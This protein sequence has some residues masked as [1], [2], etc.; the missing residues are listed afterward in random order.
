MEFSK[1]K[2]S[3][4][5]PPYIASFP[6]PLS[7]FSITFLSFPSPSLF[8]PLPPLSHPTPMPFLFPISIFF[9]LPLPVLL[10]FLL[11]AQV[12]LKELYK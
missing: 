2:F 11:L 5:F 7:P 3:H 9:S 8:L 4:Y 6:Y 1:N 10:S 12:N